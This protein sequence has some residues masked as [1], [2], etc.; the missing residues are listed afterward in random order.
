MLKLLSTEI[1]NKDM[2]RT[3]CILEIEIE[4]YL[5]NRIIKSYSIKNKKLKNRNNIEI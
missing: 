2:P 4:L 3:L 5:R 1:E